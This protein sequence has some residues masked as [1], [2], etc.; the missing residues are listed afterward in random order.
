VPCAGPARAHEA[1]ETD[2]TI[3][4][5]APSE[6][7]AVQRARSRP[8]VRAGAPLQIHRVRGRDLVDALERA[9]RTYGEHALVLSREPAPGGGHH[10]CDWRRC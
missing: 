5:V 2:A 1:L 9:A 8:P 10:G 6:L 7:R 3:A 4:P